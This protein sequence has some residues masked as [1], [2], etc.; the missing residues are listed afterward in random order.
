MYCDYDVFKE[1]PELFWCMARA[2]MMEIHENQGGSI[3]DALAT[4]RFLSAKEND[5]HVA[6]S[7]LEALGL[8][9]CVITQNIDGLHQ[10]AGSKNVI[11]LHGNCRTCTCMSCGTKFPMSEALAQWVAFAAARPAAAAVDEGD[12]FVPRHAAC[13]GVLKGDVTMFG[14]PL[15]A[16]A[17]ARAAAGVLSG[18]ACLV[19][20]SSLRVAPASAVPAL[21]RLR[22]GR[23]LVCD[24]DPAAAAAGVARAGDLLLRGRAEA[25]LPS[26]V[27]RVRALR[28]AGPG[29]RSCVC[30]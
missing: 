14:E 17:M 22:F 1:R 2:L 8:V 10:L 27:A 5:A 23:L 11:E 24:T 9:R 13:G 4:G 25:V 15:P 29:P 18:G 7:E 16:G 20:G 3:R 26:V 30:M 19:V 6:I 12:G 21:V 28:A